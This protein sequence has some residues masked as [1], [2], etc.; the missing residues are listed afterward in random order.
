MPIRPPRK[1]EPTQA[2]M[3]KIIRQEIREGRPQKQAVAIAYASA[4]KAG[5]KVPKRPK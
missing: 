4:R 3:S 5:R 2:Y 1:G